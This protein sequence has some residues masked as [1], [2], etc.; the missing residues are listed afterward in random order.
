MRLLIFFKI[1]LYF[2]RFTENILLIICL[3][4]HAEIYININNHNLFAWLICELP[5][6]KSVWLRLHTAPLIGF[7]NIRSYETGQS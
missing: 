5:L 1:N 3:K 4:M 7:D 2:L 6:C